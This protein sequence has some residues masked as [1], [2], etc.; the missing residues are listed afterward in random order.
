MIKGY[1]SK[2]QKNLGQPPSWSDMLEHLMDFL[3]RPSVLISILLLV[4]LVY[5]SA[6]NG[7][8]Q[9]ELNEMHTKLDKFESKE[10]RLSNQL[11]S[12]NSVIKDVKMIEDDLVSKEN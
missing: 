12:M 5:V 2:I 4:V 8:M 3:Q 7:A 1:Q 9:R 11:N 6:Q 10:N